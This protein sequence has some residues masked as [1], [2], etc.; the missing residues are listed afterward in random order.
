MTRTVITVTVAMAAPSPSLT[1]TMKQDPSMHE[2][3][4]SK[5]QRLGYAPWFEPGWVTQFTD[6]AP[7]PGSGQDDASREARRCG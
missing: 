2:S 5:K 7:P 4:A 6:L 1:V 3:G